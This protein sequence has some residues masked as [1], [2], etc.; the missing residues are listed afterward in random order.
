MKK[1]FLSLFMVIAITIF[2]F[3]PTMVTA[4]SYDLNDGDIIN[5]YNIT[6][7]VVTLYVG[8]IS[9]DGT[10][11][12]KYLYTDKSVNTE[13]L[14]EIDK[15]LTGD[16][17]TMLPTTAG[18][19]K[20]S[21]DNT[22]TVNDVFTDAG[23]VAANKYPDG[24]VTDTSSTILYS[25]TDYNNLTY[26]SLQEVSDEKVAEL[27]NYGAWTT[28]KNQWDTN[29]QNKE[30][31]DPEYAPVSFPE[32]YR[33]AFKDTTTY[34]TSSFFIADNKGE[35][36]I[37][38]IIRNGGV[39]QVN[40]YPLNRT[41]IKVVNTSANV[42]TSSTTQ[43]GHN[44]IWTTSGGQVAVLYENRDTS[45]QADLDGNHYVDLG[46][47]VDYVVGDSITVKAKANDGYKFV[48]WYVSDVQKGAEYYYRDQLVSTNAN[49]TYQPG[50]TTISGIDGTINYLTAA[51]EEDNT[52][53]YTISNDIATAIFTFEKNH[54]FAL[55]MIDLLSINPEDAE[56]IFGVD[57][58]TFNTT[59]ET[60]KNSAKEYGDVL[61]IYNIL[62]DDGN[63]GYT[64]S[65]KLKIK[66]TEAMKKYNT[67]KLLYLDDANNFKVAD[68]KDLIINST[69]ADVDLDHLS[70]YAL[71]GSNT[72]T[73]TDTTTT[74]DTSSN[75][76]TG[77]NIMLYISM[78]GLSVIGLA[79]TGFY[80]RKKRFN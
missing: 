75:P 42:T 20:V 43:Y 52:K 30:N 63:I 6:S 7:D 56:E 54:D 15:I 41:I 45:E 48:G 73:T 66:L 25:T 29:E 10:S 26:A 34:P 23:L 3:A 2:Q 62:I 79:G 17:K 33:N 14:N 38:Y 67:L 1:K 61:S 71:V 5:S 64:D 18:Q 57:V 16:Y 78:L 70:V 68:V 31:V 44:N 27:A 13:T 53:E 74:T 47:V 36:N 77:D 76:Q 49:Y 40:T 80:V 46:H 4:L 37:G 69:T 8:N 12:L 60:M 21:N 28:R 55:N 39:A 58:E 9:V 19:I 50:V 65:V 24:T 32:E 22:V 72:E 51:F 35:A 59:L 11:T